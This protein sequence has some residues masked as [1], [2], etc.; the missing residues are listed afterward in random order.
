MAKTNR[1]ERQAKASVILAAAGAVFMLAGAFFVLDAFDWENRWVAYNPQTL[2]FPA[3]AGA[4]LLGLAGGTGGFFVGLNSAGQRL[5]KKSK[6]SWMGFFVGAA[7]IA[8]SLS[9][10]AFFYLTKY[11]ITP[12]P[13]G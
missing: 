6:L 1:Y 11:A 7:V 12:S 9:C 4:L 10:A 5:N 13:A 3:I 8:L 2:R